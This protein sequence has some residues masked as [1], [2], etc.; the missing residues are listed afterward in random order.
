VTVFDR[1]RYYGAS[2]FEFPGVVD[3]RR[4]ESADAQGPDLPDAEGLLW[5]VPIAGTDYTCS[6]GEATG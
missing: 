3:Q 1:L 2:L 6:Q 4:D 5:A